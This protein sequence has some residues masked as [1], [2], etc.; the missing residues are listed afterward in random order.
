[1]GIP[2]YERVEIEDKSYLVCAECRRPGWTGY[3]VCYTVPQPGP[4]LPKGHAQALCRDCYWKQ[5][6]RIYPGEALPDVEETT[7]EWAVP[8]PWEGL[9]L[10]ANTDEIIAQKKALDIEHLEKLILERREASESAERQLKEIK[11]D[12][13]TVVY[14]E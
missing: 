3:R 11:G 5:W 6:Q 14:R 2:S 4:P 9:D 7:P 13:I 12:E 10:T 1:M 8:V